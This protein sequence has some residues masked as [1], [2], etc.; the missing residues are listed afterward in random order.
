M[1]VLQGGPA[2]VRGRDT[3]HSLS[4]CCERP[5]RGTRSPV[6]TVVQ[7]V[8]HRTEELGASPVTPEPPHL[9]PGRVAV[10]TEDAAHPSEPKARTKTHRDAASVFPQRH[11]RGALALGAS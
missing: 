3:S 10:T 9:T 5:V 6:R 11:P 2:G 1:D 7:G 8:P 4:V